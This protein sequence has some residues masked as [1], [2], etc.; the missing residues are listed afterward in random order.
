VAEPSGFMV[1]LCPSAE[2][3]DEDGTRAAAVPSG[4]QPRMRNGLDI[5]L[6]GGR[7]PSLVRGTAA[8]LVC[9]FTGDKLTISRPSSRGRLASS[10]MVGPRA[11]VAGV[12]AG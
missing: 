8:G 12:V 6:A 11:M 3:V 7:L 2:R 4:G 10:A 9:L 1:V 5:A